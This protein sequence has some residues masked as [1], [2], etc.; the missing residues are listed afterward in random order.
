VGKV[1]IS[2]SSNAIGF[3]DGQGKIPL[4][5]GENEGRVLFLNTKAL[6]ARVKDFLVVRTGDLGGLWKSFKKFLGSWMFGYTVL[7]VN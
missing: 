1:K 7:E 3:G 4:F 2:F 6:P 5:F